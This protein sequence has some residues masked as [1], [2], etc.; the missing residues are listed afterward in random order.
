[1]AEAPDHHHNRKRG[2]FVEMDGVVQ[3]GPAPR[4]SVT[5]PE[6]GRAPTAP[7]NDTDRVATAA[8]FSEEQIVKLRESGAIA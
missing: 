1:M 2:T 8:G 7:G 5:P 3:P 4:F 6:I